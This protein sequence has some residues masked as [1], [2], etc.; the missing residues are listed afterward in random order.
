VSDKPE[1]LVCWTCLHELGADMRGLARE[2]EGAEV[3]EDCALCKLTP[4]RVPAGEHEPMADMV[5]AALL[6]HLLIEER[7]YLRAKLKDLELV[8]P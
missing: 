8:K 3:E 1:L 4:R 7:R 6:A 5:P 2:P